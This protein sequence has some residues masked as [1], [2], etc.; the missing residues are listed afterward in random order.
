MTRYRLGVLLGAVALSLGLASPALAAQPTAPS[1]RATV[2]G[3]WGIYGWY[4]SLTE[5]RDVGNYL[6][7]GLGFYS[8]YSCSRDGSMWDLWVY[9]PY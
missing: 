6:V 4:P 2:E 1:S 5:C 8:N 7:Y 3:Y 9:D